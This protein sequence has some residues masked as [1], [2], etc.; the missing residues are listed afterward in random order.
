MLEDEYHGAEAAHREIGACV[1]CRMIDEESVR[2]VRMIGRTEQLVAIARSYGA[3]LVS[4]QRA[5]RQRQQVARATGL[6]VSA[7]R[8]ARAGWDRIAIYRA[9]RS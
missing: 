3:R 9:T 1:F 5:A 7:T 4:A 8:A 2:D 6:L